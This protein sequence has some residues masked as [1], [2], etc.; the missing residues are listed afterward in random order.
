[1]ELPRVTISG[2]IWRIV[3][4]APHIMA[5]SEGRVMPTPR[6]EP[7]PDGRGYRAY[8]GCPTWGTGDRQQGRFVFTIGRKTYRVAPLVCE[9]FHGPRPSGMVCLHINE[10]ASCNRASNLRWGTHTENYQAPGYLQYCR[11]RTGEHSTA[12]KARRKRDAE[13]I[14]KL[15]QCDMF[16]STM[17]KAE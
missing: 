1:M 10:N 8:G 9:A 13:W 4:S 15:K 5:S 11:N 17:A 3:P 6:N 14:A 2:E 7:T 16:D 12:A